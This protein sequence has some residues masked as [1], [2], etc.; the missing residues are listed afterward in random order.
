MT[1]CAGFPLGIYEI[2]MSAAILSGP[3]HQGALTFGMGYKVV[4]EWGGGAGVIMDGAT[5][6]RRAEFLHSSQQL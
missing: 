4:T 1:V 3:E 6:Q 2:Y 5:A